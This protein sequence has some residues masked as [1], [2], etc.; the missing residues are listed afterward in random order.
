VQQPA[1]LDPA[2]ICQHPSSVRWF[3]AMFTS[4]LLDSEV[5]QELVT[6]GELEYAE[7]ISA[8]WVV[9]SLCYFGAW[10]EHSRT[11]VVELA[12]SRLRR[13]LEDPDNREV[14]G[15]DPE[16]WAFA[17]QI[18]KVLSLASSRP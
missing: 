6:L 12:Q 11:R 13:V 4:T 9:A 5:E 15:G 3:A 2:P 17:R 7:I 8:C 16:L 1:P 14:L 10:P 18:M